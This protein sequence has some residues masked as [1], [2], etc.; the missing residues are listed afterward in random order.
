MLLPAALVN[1]MIT[2]F[3]ILYIDSIP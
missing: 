3:V 1:V 2:A